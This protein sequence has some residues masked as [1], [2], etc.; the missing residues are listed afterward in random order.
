MCILDLLDRGEVPP[1]KRVLEGRQFL[2]VQ[3]SGVGTIGVAHIIVYM[4]SQEYNMYSRTIRQ[5]VGTPDPMGAQGQAVVRSWI[6]GGWAL[7][8]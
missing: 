7:C 4:C 2:A 1:V 8:A 3:F 5:Q 6:F